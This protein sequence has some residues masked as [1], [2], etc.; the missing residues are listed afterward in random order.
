MESASLTYPQDG[1]LGEANAARLSGA[2]PAWHPA[3]PLGRLYLAILLSCGLYI[4]LWS[5]RLAEDLRRHDDRIRPWRYGL[6]VAL[7]VV[8]WLLLYRLARGIKALREGA[9]Q[10]FGP[11]AFAAAESAIALIALYQFGLLALPQEPVVIGIA[12]LVVLALLPLPFLF[13]QHRLNA[14]KASLGQE[15]QAAGAAARPETEKTFYLALGVFLMGLAL[16]AGYAWTS[17]TAVRARGT[18][19]AAGWPVTGVSGLYSLA[20]PDEGWVRVGEDD[21]RG[22]TD[23]S[24][25]GASAQTTL[26]VYVECD[27]LSL[28]DR[29]DFRRGK[30]RQSLTELSISERRVLLPGTAVPVSYAHYDGRAKK[31]GKRRAWRVATAARDDFL[32]EVVAGSSGNALERTTMESLVKSLSL[33]ADATSCA[34]S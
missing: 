33:R 10:R 8:G 30:M 3:M 27:P 2:A 1:G 4:L 9:G 34:E 19:I 29:V 21:I 12:L 14:F 11:T 6:G 32:V 24:L 25:Y 20:A 15:A 18:P 31:D 5:Q 13:L 28:D 26:V 23:L 7:P 17:D 22:G 16:H